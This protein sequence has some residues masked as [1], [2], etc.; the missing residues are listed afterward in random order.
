MSGE[1]RTVDRL[2]GAWQI[3]Q[4]AKGH[5]FSADD[6]LTAW[7]AARAAPSARR[8]LDLG[9]GIGS[10]GLMTL[11][12]L[13]EAVLTTVEV[14]ELSH[15]LQLETL[16]LN[17]LE[18]RV[19]TILSDLRSARLEADFDLITGSPP[20]IPEGAGVLPAHSQKAGARFEL[21]GDVF[22]Y[23]SK[24]ASVLVRDGTFVFCHSGVD[25]RPEQAIAEAGLTLIE[26]R[27]VFFG[28]G[29]PPTVALFTCRFSGDREDVE[30]LVIR[31][32]SGS[33]TREY[34][35]IRRVFD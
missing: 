24:A 6:M 10:V 23:C 12:Q 5:R 32:A 30:P 31:D 19:T 8:L 11:Y 34:T 18:D 20:Y 1:A 26:R 3:V 33:H 7:T 17:G 9:S 25:P 16:A 2:A 15:R 4:L 14:Q 13:P 22:D 29:K 21:K 28:P 27:D 35:A